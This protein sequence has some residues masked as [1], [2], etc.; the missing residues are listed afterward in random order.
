MIVHRTLKLSVYFELKPRFRAKVTHRYSR[1]VCFLSPV[2]ILST[3][4]LSLDFKRENYNLYAIIE[5]RCFTLTGRI[6]IQL[7][8]I[9][10]QI[11]VLSILKDLR[12][13][14]IKI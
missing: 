8:K 1:S 12:S 6:K 7:I 3:Y 11:Y 14:T 9:V 2:S 4:I 13:L 10:L 5:Q